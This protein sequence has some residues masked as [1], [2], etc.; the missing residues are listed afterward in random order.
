M[1]EFERSGRVRTSQLGVHML[2]LE[3][4][5]YTLL[6]TTKMALQTRASLCYFGIP[7]AAMK[8]SCASIKN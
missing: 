4:I 5:I 6:T 7:V 2:N 8:Y 3:V 1:I